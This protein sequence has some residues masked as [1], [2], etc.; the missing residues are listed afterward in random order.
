VSE[1]VIR[2]KQQLINEARNQVGA[3]Y[4]WSAAGNT[5]GNKDGASYRPLKAELH[6]NVPDFEAVSRDRFAAASKFRVQAP[7]LFTAYAD[8]SD[9]GLLACTGR[10]AMITTPLALADMNS[11]LGR[12]LDLKWKSLT[13]KQVDELQQNAATPDSFRW[14]RPNSSLNNG[15]VHRSTVWGESCVGVRHFDCIGFV[16]WC[17]SEVLT[18]PVQYGI[19][20]FVSGAVGKK[21][22]TAN[23]DLGDIVTIGADH[24]GF[25]SEAGTVIEARDATSG[26]V[27]QP[28]S[29]AR[30]TQCFRLPD[31]MWR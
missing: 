28:F 2:L 31:S 9:F 1:E 23:A 24:I 3:H 5:P 8:T 12:A 6:P 14:P 7:M 17:L 27:E 16:N 26:V 29:P 15:S 4:L 10:A 30:W 22:P 25:V 11:N 18:Q 19:P 21:I 20:N 13:D